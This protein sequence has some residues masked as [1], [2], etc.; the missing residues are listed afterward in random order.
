MKYLK[1]LTGP[2]AAIALMVFSVQAGQAQQQPDPVVELRR[3]LAH[4]TDRFFIEVENYLPVYAALRVHE[5]KLYRKFIAKIRASARAGVDVDLLGG[6]AYPLLADYVAKK[7]PLAPDE[8]LLQVARA[9]MARAK[10]LQIRNAAMCVKL[11]IGQPTGNMTPYLSQ[12]VNMEA[13]RA[14]DALIRTPR[15]A[16]A[17]RLT[18]HELGEAML[19]L[20]AAGAGQ[21][22][23]TFDDYVQAMEGKA[24]PATSCTVGLSFLAQLMALPKDQAARVIRSL[25]MMDAK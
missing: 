4:D 20:A 18:D 2:L 23:M 10:E 6:A 7:L 14:I 3:L 8:V 9:D 1:L 15:I 17:S 21:L 13:L 11:L 5:P 25:H 16:K 24:D 22:N 19:P 12:E